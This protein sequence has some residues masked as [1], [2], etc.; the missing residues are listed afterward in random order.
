MSMPNEYLS[1]PKNIKSYESQ[2]TSVVK[3]HKWR[4]SSM[5]CLDI[6]NSLFKGPPLHSASTDKIPFQTNLLS[7]RP[8]IVPAHP[9][10]VCFSSWVS[11]PCQPT[12]CHPPMGNRGTPPSWYHEACPSSLQLCSPLWPSVACGVLLLQLGEYVTSKL[13]SV[14]VPSVG[15]YVFSHP[16]K[17]PSS[18]V[19]YK[20]GN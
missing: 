11:V 9:W 13:L 3:G 19:G 12:E 14:S 16:H 17:I 7:R 15:C 1:I 8:G 5:C 4:P 2:V 6:C 10:A 20:R 18:P